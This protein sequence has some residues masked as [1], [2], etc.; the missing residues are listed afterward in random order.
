M[1]ADAQCPTFKSMCSTRFRTRMENLLTLVK[2]YPVL[3]RI[4]DENPDWKM[5]SEV[6]LSVATSAFVV[7]KHLLSMV[8]FFDSKNTSRPGEYF[9]CLLFLL[10]VATTTSEQRIDAKIQELYLSCPIFSKIYTSIKDN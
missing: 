4:Q 3:K 7:Y 1:I 5:I 8:K 10:N 9:Q 6:D 2:L